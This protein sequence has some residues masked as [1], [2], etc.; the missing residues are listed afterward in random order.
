MAD[1]VVYVGSFDRKLYAYDAGGTMSCS[2]IPKTCAPIWTATTG[3]RVLSSP[4]VVNGIVYVGS[5]DYNFYAFG[6][7]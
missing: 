5:S 7:P 1:G 2:G 4:T 3:A 6:L